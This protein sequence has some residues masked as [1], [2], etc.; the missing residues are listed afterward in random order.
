MPMLAMVVGMDGGGGSVKEAARALGLSNRARPLVGKV[1]AYVCGDKPI[2]AI[3]PGDRNVSTARLAKAAGTPR[4]GLRAASPDECQAFFGFAHP[5]MPPGGFPGPL[6]AIVDSALL[7]SNGHPDDPVVFRAGRPDVFLV[8]TRGQLVSISGLP[9]SHNSQPAIMPRDSDRTAAQYVFA[10]ISAE[11]SVTSAASQECSW[12]GPLAID[13]LPSGR[14]A[15]ISAMQAAAAAA[16]VVS[17]SAESRTGSTKSKLH[18]VSDDSPTF[19]N[20]AELCCGEGPAGL[21]CTSVGSLLV[22]VSPE[23]G[24]QACG[25]R[26]ATDQTLLGR[27]VRWLRCLGVDTVGGTGLDRRQFLQLLVQEGRVG[28][29]RDSKLFRGA[30]A[31]GQWA[32]G[33]RQCYYVGAEDPVKGFREIVEHFALSFST[34]VLLQL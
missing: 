11:Q 15:A 19:D 13:E 12:D 27:T 34:K 5:G 7:P 21:P 32:V 1:L 24:G 2:A 14:A 26:F 25:L 30:A 17:S 4:R 28:L 6:L 16:K 8:L 29:T 9:T 33:L 20:H 23:D 10:D 22:G 18:L 3:M 31:A